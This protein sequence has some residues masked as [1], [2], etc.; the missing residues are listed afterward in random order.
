MR[1]VLVLSLLL[2]IFNNKWQ[3]EAEGVE[4]SNC[5][6]GNECGTGAECT[7]LNCSWCNGWC[8][9]KSKRRNFLDRIQYGT[10]EMAYKIP[11]I[12]MTQDLIERIQTNAISNS[13]V[14]QFFKDVS[15]RCN[16]DIELCNNRAELRE[17]SEL[18][19]TKSR[20]TGS[21]LT[22]ARE[23]L[24]LITT[25]PEDIII[26]VSPPSKICDA[27]PGLLI[28]GGDG[29]SAEIWYQD[30]DSNT[31]CF[32]PSIPHAR[33]DGTLN[34]NKFCGGY[35]GSSDCIEFKNGGWRASNVISDWKSRHTSWETRNG[36]YLIG[37]ASTDSSRMATLVKADGTSS[38]G[39]SLRSDI[40]MACAIPDEDSVVLTGGFYTQQEVTR[41]NEQGYQ[42]TLPSLRSKFY[43]HHCSWYINA[44]RKMV[45]IVRGGSAS[46]SHAQLL[47]K[48]DYYWRYTQNGPTGVTDALLVNAYNRIYLAGGRDGST[49]PIY[50]FDT[51]RET[52]TMVGQSRDTRYGA[53]A[54]LIKL[55]DFKSYFTNCR[56]TY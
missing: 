17:F 16:Y 49:M 32:I 54:S 15:D 47:V 23:L 34:G 40:Y 27:A 13:D 19:L 14:I 37:G 48:G 56:K 28:V 8:R 36:I 50:E 6:T 29:T 25:L 42:E 53:Q 2:Y 4:C 52:W 44:Q 12:L 21:A 22:D 51:R 55:G 31:S 24:K 26:S 30:G 7:I 5:G 3:A 41:Y 45:Y 11:Y 10:Q 43:G 18:A 46:G 35:G 38:S 9:P 1:K 39:F 20:S 33:R